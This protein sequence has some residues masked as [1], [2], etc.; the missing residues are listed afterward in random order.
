M[1]DRSEDISQRKVARIVGVLFILGFTG[2]VTAVFTTPVLDSPDYLIKASANANQM[3][4]G[5]LFQFIMAA[6]CAGIGISLYPVLKKYSEGLALGAAGFRIIEAVFQI[7]GVVIL[8]VLVTLSQEF[9]KAGAS[10][11]SYFQTTGALLLAGNAWV[12]HVAVSLAWSIGALM[13]YYIFYRTKLIPRWLSGWGLVGITL[14]IVA[15]VSVM[16]RL[17]DPFSTIEVVLNLPIALQ[18]MVLAVW[19]I[20]KGFNPSAIAAGSAKQMQTS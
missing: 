15:S 19:L 3:T 2:V 8:L 18:E 7:V 20:A 4:I 6:A 1:T 13:Y 16:F 5:A 14:T 17:I 12:N 9:V 11:S 10:A